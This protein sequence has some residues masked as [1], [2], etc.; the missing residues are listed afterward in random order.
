MD[1]HPIQG[2]GGGW[3]SRNTLRPLRLYA[4]FYHY[5]DGSETKCEL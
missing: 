4:D 5:W 2:G 1:L 3:E